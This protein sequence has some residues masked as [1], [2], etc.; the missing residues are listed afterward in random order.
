M[1][2]VPSQHGAG[3][4]SASGSPQPQTWIFREPMVVMP[5]GSVVQAAVAMG[6]SASS[7][8]P[9]APPALQH[10]AHRPHA[11]SVSASPACSEDD[12][13]RAAQ[14]ILRGVDHRSTTTSPA[15]AEREAARIFAEVHQQPP[16]QQQQPR[17]L[18]DLQVTN[19][20]VTC[21]RPGAAAADGSLKAELA[22]L[23]GELA[24]AGVA[25][26]DALRSELRDATRLIR[27]MYD[28]NGELEA[29]LR[30]AGLQP[31]PARQPQAAR[32][33]G[34][35]GGAAT[36]RDLAAA[37]T[38]AAAA[39]AAP[40]PYKSPPAP[41]DAAAPSP[42]TSYPYRGDGYDAYRP[43]LFQQQQPPAAAAPAPREASSQP[44]RASSSRASSMASS[45][46]GPPRSVRS[47]ASEVQ[48]ARMGKQ[49]TAIA[50]DNDVVSLSSCGSVGGGADGGGG[51]RMGKQNTAIA[52]DNDVVS[53]SSCGG[54]AA[55]LGYSGGGASDA[56]FAGGDDDD[57]VAASIA[58]SAARSG[59]AASAT[60]A[61][62]AAQARMGKQN[63]AIAC[64]NDVVSLSSCGSAGGGGGGGGGGGERMGKQNTAI[65]CD[66]DVVSLSSC[67]GGSVARSERS[68]A[69][70][71]DGGATAAAAADD[72][73]RASV[74]SRT[75]VTS[76][77]KQR[78][79]KE[80]TAIACDN[81]VVDLDDM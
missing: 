11:R 43:S 45:A 54:D 37:T 63:T 74:A 5:V 78:M 73:D 33:G 59:S 41:E 34:G 77:N 76:A 47:A 79:G 46:G 27:Q 6:P 28:R 29:Q 72:D 35:G 30:H 32:G 57:D 62:S 56:S 69:A 51:E 70:S 12:A 64:D 48:Q 19:R 16:Q 52:C 61:A 18:V 21:T 71:H 24:A 14:R 13:R 3:G 8:S 40:Q 15:E 58:S 38:A 36:L 66:N 25:R 49:N 31:S 7:S 53:L 22:L 55:A 42:Y 65:A 44:R 75:S 23:R 4:H 39:A 2:V 68:V 81:D 80:N 1:S 60:S 10:H 50:C 67:G 9:A 17:Y 26:D 20:E